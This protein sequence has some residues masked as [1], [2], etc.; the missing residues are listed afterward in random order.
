MDSASF[1]Q[2][3]NAPD[4]RI[5]IVGRAGRFPA[6]RNVPEFWAMLAE[7]RVATQMRS[8]ADLLAAGVSPRLLAD[9]NYVRAAN[10]LPDMECFDAGFFGFSPRDASILDPQHR[11]F[12][13]C[14]WEALEDAGHMPERFGGKIGV[15]AGSGMQAYLPFNLL[16]NP[17]L[18]EDVGMFLLRHTGNDK[19]FL[20][21]RLSYLLNLTGP[22]VAVQT[23]C[24]TSLVAVHMGV[25]AL[26]NM[27]CDMVLAGGVTIELPHR[28]G[29]L[30]AEG[31]ILSPDGLCRAFDDASEGTVFGSGAAMVV[32]RRYADAVADG[33]DIKAVILGS[34]IN[35]DGSGKASYL[36]PSVDGQAEAAAE[37]LALAGLE[38]GDISYIEAHGTGTPIGDPIELLALQQVYGAA[39]SGS[40]GIGSVKTNIGHLDTA[41]GAASLIKVVEALRHGHLPASLNFRTPNSRFDFAGSPFR[42]LAEGRAWPREGR[43]RR[44]AINSLGVG[45]TNA[46]LIV[47]EAPPAQV[48]GPDA[49]GWQIFPFSTRTPAA[50][51]ATRARWVDFLGRP[52][53]PEACDIAHTL[54]TGRRAFP[55]RL[56]IAAR[57]AGDLA[58][59]MTEARSPL[60]LTGRA[61][62]KPPKVLFL[63]PGGG[64]QYPGAGAG[65]LAQSPVFAKAVADCFAALPADVPVDLHDTMFRSTLEDAP[66]RQ[67]LGQS[68]YAIPALFIL[69]YAYAQVWKDWG[70]TPDAIL[71][72]SVGE[73]AGAVTAGILG[74]GDALRIV[75]LRGRVM[76]DAP[77]GAMTTL[78]VDEGRARELIG[79]DLDIAALNGREATVISGPIEAISALEARLQGSEHEPRRI[80]IDVAAHSRQLEGQ[81]ERFRAG[82]AGVRFGKATVPMLSSLRGDWGQ[83]DDFASADYWVR[84]LRH[85]VRFA[86]TVEKA[87]EDPNWVVIEVGPGQTLGPLVAEIAEARAILP[88]APRV[89][90]RVDEMGVALAAL[91][92]LWAH[93]V[94]CLPATKGRRI[95]LPTYAFERQ[96]H[97]V[98]PG[99]GAAAP[100]EGADARAPL[101]RISP[102]DQWFETPAWQAEPDRAGAVDLAGEWLVLAGADAI[103]NAVLAR[104]S[105]ASA[106]V[107][108]VRAGP[109]FA[110]GADG[111]VLRPDNPDDF[112]A[113]ADALPRV[114]E[115]ILSLFALD[116]ATQ[117][118]AFDA[119]YLVARLLQGA[120]I[121]AGT[122]LGLASV[123]AA[124]VRGEAARAPEGAM[125]I[126]PLRVAPREVPGLATVL[127]DVDGEAGPEQAADGLL[128]AVT[129]QEGAGS[130]HIAVRDGQN[131]VLR[132]ARMPVP[133]PQGLP[134]RLRQGGSYVVTGG[135]GGIGRLMALWLARAAGAKLTLVSRNALEDAALR[136]SIEAAGGKVLFAKADVA[137]RAALA[138]ALDQARAAFGAIH[139]VIH[140]A[141]VMQDAP[142]GVKSLEEAHSVMAPKVMGG[143]N[144]AALLP[145]G[146]L[147][148]LA[149]I[150]STS[151]VIGPPGQTD[152]V[153][154]N[155]WL[156]ALAASR[157][158]GLSIAWGVWRDTGMAARSY[159]PEQ[160]VT[161]AGAN[162]VLGLRENKADGCVTFTTMRHPVKDWVL[163][164][165][166]VAGVP[167]LPGTA[168]LEL[169]QMAA[170]DV[171]G[172]QPFEMV[173]LSL[174]SPMA[175]VDAKPRQ[176]T[177]RMVPIRNGYDLSVESARVA[178]G[179]AI[180]HAR[181]QI[182]SVSKADGSLPAR[183]S[184]K[185]PVGRAAPGGEAAQAGII[186]FGPRWQNTG[187][188]HLAADEAAG[189]FALPDV[190]RSDLATHA[191]HPAL[192]DMAMTVGLNLIA[193]ITDQGATLVHVPMSA[194]R[195]RVFRPI[196]ARLTSRAILVRHDPGRVA[197]FDVLLSDPSGA[198]IAV[199][200]RLTMRA[201]EAATLNA[202]ALPAVEPQRLT[203]ELLHTGIQSTEAEALFG[204]V[205]S[206]AVRG[207]VI[208]PVDLNVVRL[209]LA[210]PAAPRP[211]ERKP[212]AKAG[213][214]GV[215]R[216]PIAARV[217][218]IW[219]DVLGVP[220]VQAGDDF[221]G[222]GGHSLN[223]VH[224]FSRLR[225]EYQVNLPL[226]VLFE[227]P[228]VQSLSALIAARL[229]IVP[230]DGYEALP[231][232]GAQGATVPGAVPDAWN[233]LVVIA[234]GSE[235][236]RPLFCVHGAGGN[237][238]NFRA[239]AGYLDPRIPF[240]GIRALGSD[241]GVEVDATIPAMAERYVA[242][243]RQ[244]QP[245]GPYRLAG[246]SGGGVIAF[247][248]AQMLTA[249]GERVERLV[250]LDSLAPQVAR[251]G[252]TKLQKLW[253][254]RHWDMA[255]ALGWFKRR[256]GRK[257]AMQRAEAIAAHLAQG[258]EVPD[259]L[260]GQRMAESYA[261]AQ[262]IYDPAP[263]SGP[264]TIFRAKKA[265]TLFLH[266][267]SQLGWQGILTGPVDVHALACDHFTM[268]SGRTVERIGALLNSWLLE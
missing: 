190:F 168:Y 183:L 184:E 116:P 132:R 205:F 39:P 19:D 200:E 4:S 131:H 175:F 268:M 56:A 216:D 235:Y 152:Y 229:G 211:A 250:F 75:T 124:S 32:L 197:A 103:S 146:T 243:L 108:T 54:R 130:D 127:V 26:L 29:Y 83:G 224:V 136:E 70:I 134:T 35:N 259:E 244:M 38:A 140:A 245:H 145:D 119:A 204:R 147:D 49:G 192:L 225:K 101:T 18:V 161:G 73:Y 80:H 102:M 66:A 91:G 223:A 165:H 202:P 8:E 242:A 249:A 151:V 207:Q 210:E 228:T 255:F 74:L 266:A 1:P 30:F 125:L 142:L 71:A 88:S 85:T 123:G 219:G 167:I 177:L 87:L 173:S 63:F 261:A 217:A 96:R 82:F 3:S 58:T 215:I 222:L 149:V 53:V 162:P 40:I 6:A 22:S 109:A 67:R 57:S 251:Q 220:D 114:P 254:I 78:P 247:E 185:A 59:L 11:H 158:D 68:G 36:A 42:V 160:A 110:S 89:R 155:A 227:A 180:E 264:V 95:S 81:L 171:L 121:A 201:V 137:D 17:K 94:D 232:D 135:T 20:P 182:R 43:P 122:T 105:G 226:A 10:I 199:I 139:G 246:Y 237:V 45:G 188:L 239:L 150:S 112:D 191:L 240:V 99:R 236:I 196:P 193:G 41:A 153:A 61:A 221:F 98:E 113:L 16:S 186:A 198:V 252:M 31:E 248:M 267:G 133:E 257:E 170:R 92:G 55:E 93:G 128:R 148:F 258:Q 14:G 23:A 77:P 233:P 7:G 9:P 178:G 169:A 213:A 115:R 25:N 164:D 218:E 37:A 189:D 194:D 187:K 238:L 33:D 241:G 34:A 212:A 231:D 141:G 76:D 208:S 107:T 256:G 138:R 203:D 126:G 214:R 48:A 15:Y 263:Y 163:A 253:A 86:Q 72:H 154:A 234:K 195:I 159:G 179:E 176:V 144:L 260:I 2:P 90:D 106:K 230:K 46:H 97:W 13:E 21:T 64:A 157:K 172:E 120:G 79:A 65:M 166:V 209:R 111:F 181:L 174:S 100:G 12:L 28:H 69:E 156:E 5:A 117:A 118:F 62:D 129:G 262:W 84:H 27:E 47:E 44:A 206:A 143:A 52:D 265:G 24:S 51:E 104:L 50:M 60:V